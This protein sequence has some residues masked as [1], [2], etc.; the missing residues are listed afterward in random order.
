MKTISKIALFLIL[1]LLLSSCAKSKP[2]T[3]PEIYEELCHKCGEAV[4]FHKWEEVIKIA[5]DQLALYP[6]R[7]A[8]YRTLFEAF[9]AIGKEE[10]GL[11]ML[12]KAI[13]RGARVSD[14]RP[15]YKKKESSTRYQSLLKIAQ[16]NEEIAEMARAA[17]ADP[18]IWAS[19]CASG[20]PEA[21]AAFRAEMAKLPADRVS[22]IP[23][24]FQ[25]D[26]F[27]VVN[28]QIGRLLFL[29]Q[30]STQH[31]EAL[32]ACEEAVLTTESFAQFPK[33]EKP[34]SLTGGDGVAQARELVLTKI[35]SVILESNSSPSFLWAQLVTAMVKGQQEEARKLQILFVRRFPSSPLSRLALLE[36]AHDCTPTTP[37][38]P[39]GESDGC[40]LVLQ[41]PVLRLLGKPGGFEPVTAWYFEA[42]NQLPSVDYEFFSVRHFSVSLLGQD[43]SWIEGPALD[44][45]TLTLKQLR[46]QK[47][48]VHFWA[49]WCGPCMEELKTLR[50]LEGRLKGRVTVIGINFNGWKDNNGWD[51]T[52]F[53]GLFKQRG[54]NWPQILQEPRVNGK[55]A[56]RLRLNAV[57][58]FLFVGE[59]L[60]IRAAST[61]LDE[62]SLLAFAGLSEENSPAGSP[63]S[64]PQP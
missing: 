23:R 6:K 11:R 30:H 26:W 40:Q 47:V 63:V 45:S 22:I 39:V 51:Q 18:K 42:L 37:K 52:R 29:C 12:E 53:K 54:I 9:C 32:S 56:S 59:D 4:M 19:A 43:A 15:R 57:P 55:I 25:K 38:A 7:E 46:G 8:P 20:L 13:A 21:R 2:K 10:E 16:K 14:I 48:L 49:S 61:D 58:L 27:E 44:G 41:H 1:V 60:T 24:A 62:A 33:P 50:R 28:R 36:L 34:V 17:P 35:P 31:K 3:K 64:T 5:H